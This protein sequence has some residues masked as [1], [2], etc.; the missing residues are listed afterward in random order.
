[1]L[2][3]D[4]EDLIKGTQNILHTPQELKN[5]QAPIR[6]SKLTQD[7][8]SVCYQKYQ[9]SKELMSTTKYLSIKNRK[10]QAL[11]FKVQQISLVW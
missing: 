2:E 4:E 1:M 11:T 8:A 5:N 3:V 7:D 10:T 6:E 9:M